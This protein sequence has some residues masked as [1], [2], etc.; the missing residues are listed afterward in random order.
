VLLWSK[1]GLAMQW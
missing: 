1:K